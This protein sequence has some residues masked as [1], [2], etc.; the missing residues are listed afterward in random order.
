MPR[1]RRQ[2]ARPAGTPP[3]AVRGRYNTTSQQRLANVPANI[4]TSQHRITVLYD[5]A[6]T[7][8]EDQMTIS[9][10][11]VTN[12]CTHVLQYMHRSLVGDDI[13]V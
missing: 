6:R 1:C 12:M 8:I 11:K 7:V 13:V 2:A 5:E 4:S 3:G 9:G 10:A